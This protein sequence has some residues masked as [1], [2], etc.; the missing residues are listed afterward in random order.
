MFVIN[1]YIFLLFYITEIE[2]LFISIRFLLSPFFT[3]DSCIIIW[4]NDLFFWVLRLLLIILNYSLLFYSILLILRKLIIIYILFFILFLLF[5]VTFNI[6]ILYCDP[7]III[8]KFLRFNIF[9]VI[10]IRFLKL[11][12]RLFF[13]TFYC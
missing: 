1:L 4:F 13:W 10:L 5:K 7:L 11:F 3:F 2:F 6:F 8:L 12:L 9:N